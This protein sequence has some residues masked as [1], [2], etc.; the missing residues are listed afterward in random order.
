MP[1]LVP[2]TPTPP[3]VPEEPPGLSVPVISAAWTAPDG[4][5]LDLMDAGSDSGV[6]IRGD[7]VAGMGAAPREVTRQPVSV[8]GSLLRWSRAAERI[9]TLPLMIYAPSATELLALRR[10]V[11]RAFVQTTPVAGPPRRG[12]LRVTR[13]DGTWREISGVYLDG[14]EWEDNAFQGAFYDLIV[15]QLLCDP[16]WVSDEVVELEFGYL[17]PSNYLNPYET[18]MPDRTLGAATVSIVG[19]VP[20]APVWTIAGPAVSVTVRYESDGP[21][22]T[23]GQIGAGETITIDVERR[24]VTDHTGANRIADLS[25]S[26]S[27]LFEMAPGENRLLLSITGGVAG[28]SEIRLTYRPR[29]ETA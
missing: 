29:W 12:T 9:I 1:L 24:T 7:G 3:P 25:W 8:G 18:V 11:T 6:L 23:F 20:A 26:T 5:V 17:E 27:R 4:S 21:G 10:R 16:W 19:E 22:W 15:L 2:R 14:L 13:A 28:Q